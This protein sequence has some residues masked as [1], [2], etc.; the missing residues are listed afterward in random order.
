MI[1]QKFMNPIRSSLNLC[2]RNLSRLVHYNCSNV[3]SIKKNYYNVLG[4]PTDSSPEDIKTRY[5]DLAKK[6]HPDAAPNDDSLIV[7]S[8]DKEKSS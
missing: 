7:R 2:S 5:L 6:Y 4:L 3:S 8:V 1:L